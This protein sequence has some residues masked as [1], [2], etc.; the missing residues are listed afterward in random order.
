MNYKPNLS[1]TTTFENAGKILS[2]ASKA[3]G[4]FASKDANSVQYTTLNSD[5]ISLGANGVGMYTD[6]SSTG[7]NLLTNTGKITVGDTGIGMYGYEEDTTGEIT[8]G[9]SGIGIYSQGGAVNIG[10][11]STTPKI[12][13]G[14]ANATAVFTTGSAQVVTST[15]ATYNIGANSYGFC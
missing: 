3:T 2:T 8:A 9:N 6:A 12:T 4:M 13:V 5:T 10:G 11:G 1:S 14:D 15:D 7:T